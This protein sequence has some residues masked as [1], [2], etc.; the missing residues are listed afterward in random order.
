MQDN[1]QEVTKVTSLGNM[2]EKVTGI[3]INLQ[4]TKMTQIFIAY[5]LY[6]QG[7]CIYTVSLHG[8][9]CLHELSEHS[10]I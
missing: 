3:S 8:Q 10:H 6:K 1:K 2:A 7:M 9:H 4:S 5:T